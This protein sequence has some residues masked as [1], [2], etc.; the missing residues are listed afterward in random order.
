METTLIL[1]RGGLPPLSARGCQQELISLSQGQFKRTI[2]GDLIF[3][4]VQKKKYKTIISCQ[5]VAVIATDDLT[6][7]TILDVSCI[8]PLWQ[9]VSGG[10]VRLERMPV[11]GSLTVMDMEKRP[12]EILRLEGRSIDIATTDVAYISYRPLLTMQLISYSLKMDEWGGKSG[13]V[14]ELEEV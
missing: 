6:P 2:N 12:V 8:Q 11:I 13:W 9:K 7:G 4:G 3:I 1:S 10:K 14:I 5:D